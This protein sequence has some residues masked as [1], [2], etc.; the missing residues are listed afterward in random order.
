[1]RRFTYLYSVYQVDME[2]VPVSATYKQSVDGQ[3]RPSCQRH[4]TGFGVFA[5]PVCGACE[6]QCTYR[7]MDACVALDVGNVWLSVT[8]DDGSNANACLHM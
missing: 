3:L 6:Q 7:L 5:A 8:S 2:N 4:A 1:M